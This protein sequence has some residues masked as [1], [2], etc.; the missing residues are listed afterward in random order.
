MG[1]YY[2]KGTKETPEVN[3]QM[4]EGF[5][6]LSGVSLPEDPDVFYDIILE[7]LEEYFESP[8]KKTIC[9]FK[10]AYFNSASSK[11]IYDILSLIKDAMDEGHK[12]EINWLTFEEDEEMIEAG[13]EY[14]DLAEVPINI[15]YIQV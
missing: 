13:E 3:L 12:I 9:N 2:L 6:E 4:T 14:A 1:D 11:K 7:K 10:F 15:E 8:A 5:L